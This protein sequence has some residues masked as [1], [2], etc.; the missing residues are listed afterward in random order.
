MALSVCLEFARTEQTDDPFAFC[1]GAQSYLLRSEGGV[2]ASAVLNWDEELL[3]EL[4]AV[5]QPRPDP[6]LLQRLG[7]RLRQFLGAAWAEHEQRIVAAQREQQRVVLHLRSAAAEL[8]A[9]P[10]ELLT[11]RATGQHI[12]ELP[13]LLLRYEW[14]GAAPAPRPGPSRPANPSAATQGGRVL[15]AWS[16]AGGAVPAAEHIAAITQACQASAHP[17]S[18]ETD[19]L[20]RTSCGRLCAALAAADGEGAPVAVL[21]LL[22]HG[23]AA[24]STF[25]LALDSEDGDGSCV[26]VDAGRLRQL[27]EPFVPTLRLVMVAACDSGNMGVFGSRLGSVAQTLHRIGIPSV[28]ASRYPLSVAGSIRLAQVLYRQLLGELSSLESAL[29]AARQRLAQDAEQLDW[30]SLQ[31]YSRYLPPDEEIRPVE[32]RPFRGLLSFQ[33][34]DARF[35][36]G[37]DSE[38]TELGRKLAALQESGRPRFLVVAGASGTG[39]SSLV[40]AGAVPR[41]KAAE[42]RWQVV[43]LRPGR[44]AAEL[45]ALNESEAAAAQPRLIVVDQFEELFTVIDSR[46]VRNDLVRRLWRLAGSKAGHAVLITI[47]IDY[48]GRCS[49]LTLNDEGAR[50]DAIGYADAHRVLVAQMPLEGM[51]QVITEPA[52][53]VG[54]VL[55]DGL[56][57]RILRDVDAEPGALPLLEDTLDVLWQKRRGRYL[58]DAAYD[59]IDGVSGALKGRADA[60]IASLSPAEQQLARRLLVRLVH[61]ADDAAAFTRRHVAASALRPQRAAEQ[62]GHERVLGK[63]LE[64]RL[65]VIT[66][67]ADKQRV[68]VAHEALIR[69]WP[70]LQ[71]WVRADRKLLAELEQV[72]DWVAEWRQYGTLLVGRPLGV[73][74]QIVQQQPDEVSAETL[75]M[76]TAS[77]RRATGRLRFRRI[78]QVVLGLM[79]A[80]PVLYT[81]GLKKS[82]SNNEWKILEILGAMAISLILN[83]I[84]L[85]T[86]IIL[87]WRSRK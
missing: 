7:E 30:A 47:R 54:L 28:V 77:R 85:P 80:I 11:L 20:P 62:A 76:L 38:I 36:F 6:A 67:E 74:E 66:G 59:A 2:F 73:A 57:N 81:L 39:K 13:E 45:D 32:F 52:N 87:A 34:E 50:L 17:F 4:N 3:S 56:L 49:E 24:G 37:R 35:F 69:Q 86:L 64:S 31:V 15:I 26:V 79:I 51:R 21:H 25:G 41:L 60:L 8:Y 44:S 40:L 46:A 27:L 5:R 70:R 18:P 19:V 23:A 58:T 61:I 22:C 9:L 68:E 78:T 29:L 82:P 48:L 10:W 84:M 33:P 72:A 53:K 63:L 42:P 12:G 75:A 14:P 16:A 71:E 65:L 43:Y 83:I 1:V 55:E